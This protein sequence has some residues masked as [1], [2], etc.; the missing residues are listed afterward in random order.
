MGLGYARLEAGPD[1][2][3]LEWCLCAYQP[4]TM[5]PTYPSYA[6]GMV[7]IGEAPYPKGWHRCLYP[8]SVLEA[9]K[10]L[11]LA[12]PH[13]IFGVPKSLPQ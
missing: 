6:F 5:L 7:R 12:I 10:A 9:K 11:R 8:V 4:T 2:A 1:Y 3:E 13:V